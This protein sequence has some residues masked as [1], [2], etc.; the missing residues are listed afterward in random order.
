MARVACRGQA[1]KGAPHRLSR[2]SL[3]FKPLLYYEFVVP[4]VV[5]LG[6]GIMA[7]WLCHH[8]E[9]LKITST[10]LEGRNVTKIERQKFEALFWEGDVT[11][12]FSVKKGVF[13]ERGEAIQ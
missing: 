10:A 4:K 1:A 8:S 3:G 7:S 12:H 2:E 5:Q 6:G 13:S 9:A 11:K